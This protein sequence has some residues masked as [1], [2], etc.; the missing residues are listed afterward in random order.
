MRTVIVLL[1]VI[2]LLL[3][4]GPWLLCA[5]GV[6]VVAAGSALLEF[7][8]WG[9]LIGAI[10]SGAGAAIAL[11][12]RASQQARGGESSVWDTRLD[13]PI[14]VEPDRGAARREALAA[15]REAARE[16]EVEAAREAAAALS[17]VTERTCPFCAETIKTAAIVCRHCGRDVPAP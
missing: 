15:A 3:V 12:V 11:I 16:R 2:I 17:Q 10:V 1:A 9:L 5:G 6:A 8:V 13:G 14:P 4:L 7:L